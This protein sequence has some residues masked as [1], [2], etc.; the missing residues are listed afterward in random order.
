MCTSSHVVL[1]VKVICQM[2]CTQLDVKK[3]T[4]PY[5]TALFESVRMENTLLGTV[6]CE[7][8][9]FKKCL[10][11]NQN[12]RLILS[13]TLF[14]SYMSLKPTVYTLIKYGPL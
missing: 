11:N 7:L 6:R 1:C 13:S 2:C 5:S 8:V 4:A 3:K 14:K 9:Q 10:R 12:V